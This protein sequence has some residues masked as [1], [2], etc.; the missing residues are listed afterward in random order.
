MQT[1]TDREREVKSRYSGH[2]NPLPLDHQA[3]CVPLCYNRCSTLIESINAKKGSHLPSLQVNYSTLAC[4]VKI[5]LDAMESL[6][7]PGELLI[8]YQ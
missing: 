8:L 5:R 4:L 6:P 3:C 2:L 7:M 1:Q